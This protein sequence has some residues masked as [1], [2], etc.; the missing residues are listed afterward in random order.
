MSFR[1]YHNNEQSNANIENEW[2]DLQNKNDLKV[3]NLKLSVRF[4]KI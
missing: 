3:G 4:D 2:F 1:F